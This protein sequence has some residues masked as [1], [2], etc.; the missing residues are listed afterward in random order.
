MLY[1]AW[2]RLRNPNAAPDPA[3]PARLG[4]SRKP[5]R[6]EI[7]EWSWDAKA[8][9]PVAKVTNPAIEPPG[10]R[11]KSYHSAFVELEQ[12]PGPSWIFPDGRPGGWWGGR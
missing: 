7:V 8:G 11:W 6:G 1:G 12:Q 10:W 4:P 2:R 5:P 9:R 3:P